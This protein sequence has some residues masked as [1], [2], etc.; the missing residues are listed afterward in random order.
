MTH[1]VKVNIR[2]KAKPGTSKIVLIEVDAR[3]ITISVNDPGTRDAFTFKAFVQDKSYPG[4]EDGKLVKLYS[5]SEYTSGALMG[6]GPNMKAAI[7]MA[8]ARCVKVGATNMKISI[9]KMVAQYGP[10]N[11]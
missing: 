5:V 4:T 11:E 9:E 6:S 8:E 1:T 10:A 3:I 2:S 7:A